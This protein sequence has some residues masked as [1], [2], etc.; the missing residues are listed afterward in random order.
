MNDEFKKTITFI[1]RHNVD[2][3]VYDVCDQFDEAW[4]RA[5]SDPD[6]KEFF[7]NATNSMT[8][9]SQQALLQEMVIVDM[10][11]R[12]RRARSTVHLDA[13]PM[14]PKSALW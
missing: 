3:R 11:H 8:A 7:S 1:V 12:W 5:N 10:E 9:S 4:W 13:N 14:A 6:I 2:S